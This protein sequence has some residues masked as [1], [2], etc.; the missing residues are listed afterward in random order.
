[1]QKFRNTDRCRSGLTGTPGA[2]YRK[3]RG[4][5]SLLSAYFIPSK[6][7]ISQKIITNSYELDLSLLNIVELLI[8]GAG[9]FAAGMFESEVV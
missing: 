9:I 3:V 2:L 6:C 8:L 1:M 5:E 4:F 7:K